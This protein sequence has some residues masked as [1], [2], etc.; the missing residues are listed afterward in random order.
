MRYFSIIIL[1]IFI[2]VFGNNVIIPYSTFSDK[3][4]MK[5]TEAELKAIKHLYP[6][7]TME[8]L[9]SGY[10][11]YNGPCIK[12]HKQK[13]IYKRTENKWT[14]I[15]EKMSPKAHLTNSQKDDLTKYIFAMKATYVR[16]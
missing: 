11:I 2:N 5:P 3:P 1:F 6:N 16:K 14:E 12:C 13:D 10:S 4:S 7:A 9:E 8:N 15:I